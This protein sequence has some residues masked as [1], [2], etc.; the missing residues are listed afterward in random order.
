MKNFFLILTVYLLCFSCHHS[1]TNSLYQRD[2]NIPQT[3]VPSLISSVPSSD[4]RLSFSQMIRPSFFMHIY[5]TLNT[6]D[7]VFQNA[8]H[9]FQ[10]ILNASGIQK[11]KPYDLKIIDR[12]SPEAFALPDGSIIISTGAIDLCYKDVSIPVG[13]GRLGFILGHE[14]AHLS[15]EDFWHV[16]AFN[17][18]HDQAGHVSD[19]EHLIQKIVTRHNPLEKEYLADASGLKY[20]SMAGLSTKG[21]VDTENNIFEQWVIDISNVTQYEDSTH[22][23]PVSRA[24]LILSKMIHITNHLEIFSRAVR[25]YQMGKY[26][27]AF[28]FFTFFSSNYPS[29]EVL[30]NIGLSCLQ[31]AIHALN[32]SFDA[33]KISF[34]LSTIIDDT[35]RASRLRGDEDMQTHLNR[36]LS[37]LTES[38]KRDPDYLPSK[39]NLSA[40]QLLNKD[41]H[42]ALSTLKKLEGNPFIMNNRTIAEYLAGKE[43]DIDLFE[44][45]QKK[46]LTIIHQYPSFSPAYY[47]LA[48]LCYRANDSDTQKY[49][50]LY[51]DLS[52]FG[53]YATNV[54][55][56][57]META[58]SEN[59]SGLSPFYENCPIPLTELSP[60]TETRLK[61]F[62]QKKFEINNMPVLIY[63]FKQIT[64][65]VL[66]W[67]VVMVECP[68]HKKIS[69]LELLKRYKQP[70]KKFTYNNKITYVYAQFAVDI[71]KGFTE[72]V[73]FF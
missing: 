17:M 39:L 55:N 47:N 16:A 70:Y 38:C 40:A 5:Q 64:V 73:V 28:E 60:E 71:Q 11:N 14:V 57:F 54:R 26:D 44:R 37:F 21:V 29:V 46:L 41:F 32:K 43:M 36:A 20:A 51:L 66:D 19:V 3:N 49:G 65:L 33:T 27:D 15:R 50:Q 45:S 1:K 31:Q 48:N 67:E 69:E 59:R 23:D 8:H 6:D 42:G 2:L 13:D 10:Q 30:N 34:Q 24:S 18:L 62:I 12:P 58:E 68:V 4:Q 56:T 63:T 9:I 7:P 72:N 52:P 61:G 35:T 22:P 25:L 53:P